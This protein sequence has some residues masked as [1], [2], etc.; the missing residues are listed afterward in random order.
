MLHVT[1]RVGLGNNTQFHLRYGQYGKFGWHKDVNQFS[2]RWTLTLVITGIITPI[3]PISMAENTWVTGVFNPY[4]W[5][6]LYNSNGFH[7]GLFHPWNKWSYFT[8]LI[9]N[10]FFGP[11]LFK[12][13]C[14]WLSVLIQ[15]GTCRIMRWK[16]HFWWVASV[17]FFVWLYTP[18]D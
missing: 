7:W 15:M 3:S 8:L 4:K 1:Q 9:D 18:E 5:P 2:K 16:T 14:L 10:R 13:R 17:I 6:A 12:K 11:T